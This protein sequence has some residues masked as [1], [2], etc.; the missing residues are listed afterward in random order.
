M[1]DY[2]D[3]KNH[4]QHETQD[5]HYGFRLLT[6]VVRG[7]SEADDGVVLMVHTQPGEIPE[8]I[9]AEHRGDASFIGLTHE[10]A[11]ELAQFILDNTPTENPDG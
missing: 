4:R 9:T 3:T 10:A 6:T 2:F 7:I 1:T 5:K 8:V 11:R